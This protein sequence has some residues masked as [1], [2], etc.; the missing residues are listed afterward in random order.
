L[1]VLGNAQSIIVFEAP[2]AVYT[3][4]NGILA[5]GEVI[6]NSTDSNSNW[7]GFIRGVDGGFTMI[8]VP[9]ASHTI[10][11]SFNPAGTI[12]GRFV[13]ARESLTDTCAPAAVHSLRLTYPMR[14]RTADRERSPK[15]SVSPER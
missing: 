5:T 4:P 10:V 7:H 6:G 12:S 14:D 15:T 11:S 1:A 9:G 8:D 13:D 2:N 3:S